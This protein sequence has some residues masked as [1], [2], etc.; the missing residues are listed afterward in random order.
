MAAAFEGKQVYS[1]DVQVGMDIPP[2]VKGPMTQAHIMR[3]SASQ[4]NWHRI[5]YDHPFALD[6]EKLPDVVINGSWKQ[7]VMCQLIKDWV[8]LGGWLWKISF[9]HRAMNVPGDTLTAWGRVTDK[10]VQEGLGIIELEVGMR[11]QSDVEACPGRA[12][13]VLPIRGGRPVP[14]P[15]VPPQGERS[16][17]GLR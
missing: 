11:N 6:H 7:Q 14:Y 1:D 15:F 4:E 17:Q 10:Y 2:V 16:T 5:H 8:G 12:T 9:Q 3:W 13:A